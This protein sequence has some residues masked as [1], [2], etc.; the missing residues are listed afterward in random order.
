MPVRGKRPHTTCRY[1]LRPVFRV[2]Q[3]GLDVE[4]A[5]RCG[6]KY[7]ASFITSMRCSRSTIW[8]SSSIP[9]VRRGTSTDLPTLVRS[10]GLGRHLV[11]R[12]DPP[13]ITPRRA[14]DRSRAI[15][16]HDAIPPPAVDAIEPKRS[17]RGDDPLDELGGQRDVIRVAAH[18][19]H[20]AHIR[21]DGDRV[22]DEQRAAALSARGPVED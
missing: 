20:E 19:A 12:A 4:I 5:N 13:Q 15:G 8:N 9:M 10:A 18:E 2:S 6:R 21:H 14:L 16:R 11:A 3:N 7:R 17:D 1:D 22:A